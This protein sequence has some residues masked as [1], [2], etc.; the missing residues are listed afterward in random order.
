MNKQ[1]QQDYLDKYKKAKEKGVPFF[2]D[3]IFKDTIVVF[4]VFIILIALA[5][6]VGVP[7]EARANPNDANYTPRPE[8]YFL[9]LFQLLKYFPGN[10]EVVGAMILPGLFI[11]LLLLLPFIDRSPKR[12]FMT[13]PYASI[14]AI[15]VVLGIGLLTWLA[16]NEAPPPIQAAVVDKAAALYATDCANCHG[17]GIVIPEGTDLHKLIAAGNH[18]GMPAWGGDLSA[19]E[20]DMLAGFILSPNGSALFTQE[21]AS[22]HKSPVLASGNPVQL[23]K[24]FDE[25]KDFPA[26]KD[27]NTPDWKSTLTPDQ[28]N[29]LLNF[30]AAPDGQRLFAINC[31]G[32]HGEGVGFSGTKEELRAMIEKGGH[33]IKMPG[34][35]DTLSADDLNTLA[36]Y[37]VDP[38]A[39]SAGSTMF[40]KYCAACHGDKIPAAPDEAS[41]LSIIALGGSHITMPVWGEILTAEQLDALTSYTWDTSQGVGVASGEKLFASNCRGCHGKFG[42]GGPNPTFPGD[43]IF[44]ISSSEYLKTRDDATIRNIISQGQPDYGM[45]PFGSAYGGSLSDEQIDAILGF[46]RSWEANPPSVSPPKAPPVVTQPQELSASQI[47]GSLCAQCHGVNREGTASG[48]A[49]DPAQLRAEFDDQALHDMINNGVLKVAMPGLGNMFTDDQVK[50]L[51]ILVAGTETGTSTGSGTV[52][53]PP[54]NSTVSFNDQVLPIFQAKCSMCH[55][56]ATTFGGW[57]STSYQAVMTSGDN[58]PEVIAGDPD[59]SYLMQLL[60]ATNGAFM[61]PTGKLSDEEIQIIMDWIL[62]GALDN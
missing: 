46:I 61:P 38:E 18:Q 11:T 28:E 16:V 13:R 53:K 1:E 33:E 30:L 45:T 29:A 3:I 25:G 39:N 43:M 50:K 49:L 19:D 42:E 58:A 36:Q 8:W 37:V 6:F 23:Q 55:S 41:A 14:A 10:L 35:K 24:V 47:Y 34:W 60:Q 52:P 5:Y 22:C 2:P 59:N 62:A 40:G 48:P 57:D 20:I 21:C 44:P 26:H 4:I 32:C 51:V 12:H 9:F 15:V 54:T 17:Q 7:L 31:Q 56:S 27:L